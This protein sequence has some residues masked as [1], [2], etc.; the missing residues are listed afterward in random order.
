LSILLCKYKWVIGILF[1]P[2]RLKCKSASATNDAGYITLRKLRC[3]FH[4][5]LQ[6]T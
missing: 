2:F 4:C 1:A 6:K 5:S 3:N